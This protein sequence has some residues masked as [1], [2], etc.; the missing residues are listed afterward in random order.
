[1]S[2]IDQPAI[3]EIA[4]SASVNHYSWKERGRAPAGY[5]KGM[6]VSFALALEGLRN[7]DAVAAAMAVAPADSSHD[8]LAWYAD[9]LPKPAAADAEG[10]LI[11]LF[12]LMLG[13]GMRESSG[14]H[15]EGRDRSASNT[16]AETAEAGL[17]QVS[18]N[19][20]RATPTLDHLLQ[21][22]QGRTDLQDVFSEGVRCSAEAWEDWGAGAGHDFQH[23][24]K[25]CPAFAVAYTAVLLR[26][27]RKHWGPI[28]RKEAEI[29][30]E[31]TELFQAV[32]LALG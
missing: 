18:Y 20:H 21:V 6:A 29:R 12:T 22:Y 2:N 16:T 24:T 7:G 28:N 15:C 23:L 3:L 31:A 26:H 19:S 8:A 4:T 17:F 11:E 9:L 5:V 13:L 1:M 14:K 32:R 27:L 25:H 10:R 30:P